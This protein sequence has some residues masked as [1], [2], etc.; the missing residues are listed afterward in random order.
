MPNKMQSPVLK[1]ARFMADMSPEVKDTVM[2]II[3]KQED[4]PAVKATE[5]FAGLQVPVARA[6]LDIILSE[7]NKRDPDFKRP[8]RPAGKA[9]PADLVQE[10][11]A[12][13]AETPASVPQPVAAAASG[14]NPARKGRR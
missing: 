10:A 2:A 11:T 3:N 12:P 13:V 8:G 14:A 5:Y 1:L 9:K 6:I 7:V 4:H